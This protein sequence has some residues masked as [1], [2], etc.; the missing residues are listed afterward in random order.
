[1]EQSVANLLS[2]YGRTKF[3]QLFGMWIASGDMA[4]SSEAIRGRAARHFCDLYRGTPLLDDIAA[5]DYGHAEDFRNAMSKERSKTSAN[6]YFA[7]AKAFFGWLAVRGHIRINPFARVK[8]FTVEERHRKPY[9]D[10]EIARI[11]SVANTR[12]RAATLL[13]L[14]SVRRSEIGNLVVSDIDFEAG[15]IRVSP[16]RDT[17]ETWTWTVKNHQAQIVPLP[18]LIGT[19]RGPVNLHKLLL[20][21]IDELEGGQPYLFLSR[22]QYRRRLAERDAGTL[23]WDKRVNPWT[24]FS[25]D[26]RNLLL[27]AAVDHRRFHDLRGTCATRL[28]AFL[29]L[30]KVQK[31]MRHSSPAITARYIQVDRDDLVAE[32][33]GI[34]GRCY[35]TNAEIK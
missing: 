3:G 5:I 32:S 11:L 20:D 1:M 7:N 27:R 24:S 15:Y 10:E 28:G 18:E 23:T 2:K 9:K 8:M 16:K 21:L 30:A 31:L 13:G 17:P 6:I 4:E 12:W 26:W 29:P 25:R 33:A 22:G 34:L 19:L 14:S 35:G